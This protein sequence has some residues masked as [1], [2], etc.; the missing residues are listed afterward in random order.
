LSTSSCVLW[1]SAQLHHEHNR[2]ASRFLMILS[3]SRFAGL[4]GYPS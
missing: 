1:A 4:T 2:A 3:L